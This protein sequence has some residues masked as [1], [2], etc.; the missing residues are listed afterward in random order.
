MPGPDL[1]CFPLNLGEGAR[2]T[3]REREERRQCE[4]ALDEA[5]QVRGDGGVGGLRTGYMD[6]TGTDRVDLQHSAYG[7][8]VLRHNEEGGGFLSERLHW[9]TPTP[10]IEKGHGTETIDFAKKR[11]RNYL[12]CP[13]IFRDLAAAAQRIAAAHPRLYSGSSVVR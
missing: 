5:C 2:E 1:C 11:P 3:E 9:G 10:G 7:E 13:P 4:Q 8:P 12:C 6:G